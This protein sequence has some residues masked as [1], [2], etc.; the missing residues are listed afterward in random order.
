MAFANLSSS[1][2]VVSSWTIS[3]TDKSTWYG[4]MRKASF[5]FSCQIFLI[6]WAKSLSAPLVLWNFG[7]VDNLS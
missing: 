2:R 1:R 4:C 3:G 6:T 5:S 7:R